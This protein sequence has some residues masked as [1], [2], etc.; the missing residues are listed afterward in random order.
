M[1]HMLKLQGASQL[2]VPNEAV[3]AHADAVRFLWHEVFNS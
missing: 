2:G 3:S 1:Q